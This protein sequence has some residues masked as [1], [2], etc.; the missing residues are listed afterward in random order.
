MILSI[1]SVLFAQ[2]NDLYWTTLNVLN[3]LPTLFMILI[4]SSVFNVEEED[5]TIKPLKLANVQKI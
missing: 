3:V 1:L 4:N 5:F 2:V